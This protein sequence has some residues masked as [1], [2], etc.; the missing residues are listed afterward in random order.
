MSARRIMMSV[1]MSM[2]SATS[3]G[4]ASSIISGKVFSEIIAPVL[5]IIMG[6]LSIAI[7]VIVLKQN[8]D[9]ESL[10]ALTGSSETYYSQNKSKSREGKMKKV[11]VG[12]A[13]AMVIVAVAFFVLYSLA[14][15]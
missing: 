13:I 12:I 2:L 14:G 9:P 4:G 5:M 15:I 7:I 3:S 8:S 1:F 11:T 6:L 10:G